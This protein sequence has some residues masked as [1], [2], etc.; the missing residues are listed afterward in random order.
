VLCC[1]V[2]HVFVGG[3]SGNL[4]HDPHLLYTLS[5]VQLLVLCDELDRTDTDKIASC[6]CVAVYWT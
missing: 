4:K 1:V 6:M 2:I 5:A 3:F